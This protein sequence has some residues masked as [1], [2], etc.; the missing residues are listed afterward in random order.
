MIPR[1]WVAAD[2]YAELR[3]ELET[4]LRGAWHKAR[5]LADETRGPEGAIDEYP[6]E[7]RGADDIRARIFNALLE[8]DRLPRSLEAY[9]QEIYVRESSE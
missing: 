7:A 1:C 3:L 2:R 4:A 5:A 6:P 9:A 8:L